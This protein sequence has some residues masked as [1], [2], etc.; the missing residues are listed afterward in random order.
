MP[1]EFEPSRLAGRA[2]QIVAVLAGMSR[3]GSQA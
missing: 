3:I 1:D 2:L